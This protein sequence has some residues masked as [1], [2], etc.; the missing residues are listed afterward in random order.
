MK[1]SEFNI[2]TKNKVTAAFKSKAIVYTQ[3][4]VIAITVFLI[5][6]DIFLYRNH[7]DT[8]SSVIHT[9]AHDKLFV[10]TWV[11]GVLAAHLF[12]CRGKDAKT[13]P[14]LT[15]IVVLLLMA[16][17]IFLL[18]RYIQTPLPMWM[19]LIFLIF[20]AVTGYYLWPQKIK[21]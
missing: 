1:L 17:I 7:H 3:Y 18:G 12:I 19:H 9:N 13:I 2:Q 21:K 4:V 10:I 20:G 8:I 16:L 14:E 5:I 11:W 15:G 6:W